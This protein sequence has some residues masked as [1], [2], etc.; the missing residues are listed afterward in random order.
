MANNLTN[1]ELENRI[2]QLEKENEKLTGN[3]QILSQENQELQLLFDN[4]PLGYQSLS[5]D[6]TILKVNNKWAEM[7]G[8][9]KK[10]IEGRNFAELLSEKDVEKFNGAFPKFIERGF[11]KGKEYELKKK[12]GTFLK[13]NFNGNTITDEQGEFL[14]TACMFD[15]SITTK[16]LKERV[17]ELTTLYNLKHF[18][19]QTSTIEDLIK[20]VAF[21]LPQGME[22]P[23]KAH[24]RITLDNKRYCDCGMD[25]LC[26]RI[27]VSSI[28]NDIIVQGVKRGEQEVGYT[29]KELFL[30]GFENDF[31]ETHAKNLGRIIEIRERNNARHEWLETLPVAV[32]ILGFG[33]G[34]QNMEFEFLNNKFYEQAG[35]DPS[36][37]PKEIKISDVIVKEDLQIVAERIGKLKQNQQLEPAIYRY[38]KQKPD[39]IDETEIN[40]VQTFP[41]VNIKNGVPV[42]L[43]I[44]SVDVT[45]QLKSEA[46]N[47]SLFQHNLN[48]I[49]RLDSK[50]R[51]M[52]I[53]KRFIE[54][55]G[56][57]LEE[58]KG[59]EINDLIVPPE[60]LDETKK[61]SNSF[62]DGDVT[63]YK[64]TKRITKSNE[65][66]DMEIFGVPIKINENPDGGY[67]I[68]HPIAERI[69]LVQELKDA[70]EKAEES[71]KLKSS[72]LSN[73][74]H[75]IR[76]P[77]N[78]ILGFTNL[79]L[80]NAKKGG[81][82]FPLEDQ[83]HYLDII[84]NSSEKLLQLI[85][86]ILDVSKIEAG[87]ITLVEK[88]YSLR[89]V[90]ESVEQNANM[91]KKD[92]PIEIKGTYSQKAPMKIIGDELRL[93][94]VIT[95]LVA[96]AYKFTSEGKIDFGV[97]VDEIK[98]MLTVYVQDTGEGIPPDK[99]EAI[100]E[101]FTQ[102][103]SEANTLHQGTGLGLTI[104]KNLVELMGGKLSVKS[105][106]GEGSKFE[107]TIPYKVPQSY[108][109]EEIEQLNLD[110]TILENKTALIVEDDK[111]NFT[112]LDIV[113]KKQKVKT[114]E[115]SNGEEALE[116]YKNN[117]DIDFILM[118]IKLPGI[119]GLETTREIRELEKKSGKYTPIIAVTAYA[120]DSDKKD[121]QKAG[122]TDFISKPADRTDILDKITQLYIE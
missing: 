44:A 66:L 22:Q 92:K 36:T 110:Y 107:F 63:N 77:M 88:N 51:V 93:T 80:G 121:S 105:K 37:P 61:L 69:K 62:L 99:I 102:V 70:K 38:I 84:Q 12:D 89:N 56:Y 74:S 53:N 32:S 27:Y 68:Y 104:S 5:T 34:L 35:I 29:T 3:Q 122:C 23:G 112:Y 26:E 14:Q 45:E 20:L 113:L 119:D 4:A 31:L 9:S 83:V 86:D 67:G 40:Y 71:D 52:D 95:N 33:N 109:S 8:Y 111:I 48:A 39:G 114:I 91:A 1:E 24:A 16:A 60:L 101:S 87:Q 81:N 10:E 2:L 96:N 120:F 42:N 65:P 7:L 90:I 106:V 116:I 117:E 103:K 75:E 64:E 18:E 41:Q 19:S 25:D 76:S 78:G 97:E 21:D 50:D 30:E 11:V 82:T 49:A 118:D 115:V 100:F 79:L 73:T 72:F 13:V 15:D 28:T 55:F 108:K 94:Q 85:N 54:L 59:K 98:K 57:S 58:A 47:Y 17:K 46:E 43:T 6:G